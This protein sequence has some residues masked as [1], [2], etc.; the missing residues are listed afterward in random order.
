MAE[1]ELAANNNEEITSDCADKM[2]IIEPE[3]KK[4]KLEVSEK[5]PDY[6]LEERLNGILCCAVCLDLPPLA[7]FQVDSVFTIL[8][9]FTTLFRCV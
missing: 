1:T 6:K 9:N 4:R 8:S 3:A 2:D 7:V 5:E